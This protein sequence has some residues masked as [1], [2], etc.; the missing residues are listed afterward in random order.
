MLATINYEAPFC[1]VDVDADGDCDCSDGIDTCT[2]DDFLQTH[3]A[4]ADA[5]VIPKS[6]E[7]IWKVT[8]IDSWFSQTL[9]QASTLCAA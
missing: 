5:V 1:I 9:F 7:N 6:L 2:E 4:T 8:Q 3:N